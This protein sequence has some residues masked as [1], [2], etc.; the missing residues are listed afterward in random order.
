MIINLHTSIVLS[1]ILEATGTEE[2]QRKQNV[3]YFKNSLRKL[4]NNTK[5]KGKLF[6]RVPTIHIEADFSNVTQE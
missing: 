5:P 6:S 4:I 1:V 3:G 2:L